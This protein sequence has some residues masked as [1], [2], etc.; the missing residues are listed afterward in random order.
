[1]LQFALCLVVL[2]SIGNSIDDDALVKGI[3][4]TLDECTDISEAVG[5]FLYIIQGDDNR[6]REDKDGKDD[7]LAVKVSKKLKTCVAILEAVN[8]FRENHFFPWARGHIELRW[9]EISFINQELKQVSKS[10]GET[11]FIASRDGQ[12][13]NDFHKACDGKGATVVIVLTT[14]GNIFGG[15]TD[16]SW[17]TAGSYASSTKSFLFRLRPSRRHYTI[18]KGKES[19]AIYRHSSYGPIFGGGHDL[20]IVS[21]ALSSTS[22]YTNGGHGYDFPGYPNYQ[23]NDGLK[24]F[25]VRDYVVIQANSI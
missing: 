3:E 2:A 13:S 6:R 21:N 5:D 4:S 23:L 24:N 9:S 20:Y 14:S 16:Q 19:N 11:L 1:M 22:S 10:L 15:Y 8:S 25:Q 12:T 17:S 7:S 18:K